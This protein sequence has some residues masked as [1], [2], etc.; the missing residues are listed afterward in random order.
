MNTTNNPHENRNTLS[1][2]ISTAVI[3]IFFLGAC[4]GL[5]WYCCKIKKSEPDEKSDVGVDEISVDSQNS[6]ASTS[7]V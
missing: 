3:G 2:F 7:S 5:L 6:D 1:I 4:F